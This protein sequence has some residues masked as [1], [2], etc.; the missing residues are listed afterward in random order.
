MLEADLEVLIICHTDP[1]YHLP[2][3]NKVER[4]IKNIPLVIEINAYGDSE[5]S[6]FAH[7]QL[8]AAPWGEKEGTQT[9]LDRTI[10]K[11]EKLTRTSIDCKPDWEIFQ[12]IAQALGYQKAFDFKNTKEIF[13]EYQKMTKLNAYMDMDEADYDTLG[14]APFIWGEKIKHFL[15]PDKKGNLFFVENK[16]LSERSSLEYPFILLTGRTR[17]Q[18]HSGTKTNLPTTLLKYKEL[19]FCEMHPNDAKALQLEQNETIRVISKRGE[20]ITKVY[21]TDTIKEKTYLYSYQ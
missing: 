9:N 7:I 13:Q 8:P 6:K 15:T 3:R 1:V 10:T 4:L 18:W 16:L 12:L 20:L 21:I 14:S 11:Q 17:D 2:N 5:T 19:N